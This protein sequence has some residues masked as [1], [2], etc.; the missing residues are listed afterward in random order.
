MAIAL[1]SL[2]MTWHS[3]CQLYSLQCPSTPLHANVVMA[4]LHAAY[5]VIQ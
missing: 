1:P 2:L 5:V 3:C 4:S